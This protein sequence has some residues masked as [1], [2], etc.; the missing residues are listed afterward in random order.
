MRVSPRS[1]IGWGPDPI[2]KTSEIEKNDA[3]NESGTCISVTL[4]VPLETSQDYKVGGQYVQV[5]KDEDTKPLFLAIASPPSETENSCFDFLIKKTDDN[6]WMTDG[7]VEMSQVLG[8]GFPVKEEL[9]GIK[10]DF[11][12]QNVLLFAAGS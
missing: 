11:P 10:Y 3:A 9:D 6:A 12:C 1:S 2:W 5:R 7:N 4:T 8:N